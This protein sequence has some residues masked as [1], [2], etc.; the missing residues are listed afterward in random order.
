[1]FDRK[2][3]D[4]ARQGNGQHMGEMDQRVWSI[5]NYWERMREFPDI[6]TGQLENPG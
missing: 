6:W 3:R 2:E 5:W 4:G 1:M